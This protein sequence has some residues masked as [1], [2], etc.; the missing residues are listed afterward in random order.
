MSI[1]GKSALKAS[2]EI[3]NENDLPE[4]FVQKHVPEMFEAMNKLCQFI[5]KYK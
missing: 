2:M 1:L 3:G 4:D 5:R